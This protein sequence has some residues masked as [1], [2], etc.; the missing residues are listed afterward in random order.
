MKKLYQELLHRQEGVAMLIVLGFMALSVPMIT[1]LLSLAGTISKDSQ[2]KTAILQGQYSAQGCTQQAAYRINSGD[3]DSLNV[4]ES[5]NYNFDGC[6]IAVTKASVSLAQ[7]VAYADLAIVLDVSGS[8]S[9]SELADLKNAANIIVDRFNLENTDGR[10]AIGVTRFRGSSQV[11]QVMTDVDVHGTSEP[12]HT[13]I[14]DLV[15]GGEEQFDPYFPELDSGTNIVA[16]LQGGGATY[17]TGLGDRVDPPYPVPNLMVFITDGDDTWSNSYTAIENASLATNAEVFA[18]GVG[19]EVDMNTINAIATDPN[20]DHAFPIADF[21][22]LLTIIDGIVEAVYN[23]STF[24][25]LFTIESTSSNGV[26]S[27]SQVVIPPP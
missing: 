8:V 19:S 23:A 7:Q 17:A 6:T 10:V 21:A 26:V 27:E 25:T 2:T 15:Q 1:G 9:S 3:F 12:L 22:G 4:G 16:G 24:G 18:I 14:N 5:S 11:M 13:V 20:V